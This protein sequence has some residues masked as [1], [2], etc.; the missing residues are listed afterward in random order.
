MQTSASFIY[1]AGL[2]LL[3]VL[4]QNSNLGALIV[5]YIKQEDH[6]EWQVFSRRSCFIDQG[7][8]RLKCYFRFSRVS[9]KESIL[10]LNCIFMNY[11]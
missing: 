3:G 1:L 2:K 4:R 6:A 8:S 5:N 11:I 9:L 7:T 10:F